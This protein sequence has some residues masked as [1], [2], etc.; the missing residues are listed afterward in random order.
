MRLVLQ[1]L[2]RGLSVEKLVLSNSGKY[3][4]KDDQQNCRY[5]QIMSKFNQAWFASD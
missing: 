3:C 5:N 4:Q 1:G 2:M